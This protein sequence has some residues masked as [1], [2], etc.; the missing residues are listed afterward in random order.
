MPRTGVYV[1]EIFSG[2]DVSLIRSHVSPNMRLLLLEYQ[3]DVILIRKS[4]AFTES[5]LNKG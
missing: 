5:Q 3:S 1:R 2:K 4:R